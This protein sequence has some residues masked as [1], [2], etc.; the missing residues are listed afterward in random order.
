MKPFPSLSPVPPL[1]RPPAQPNPSHFR[2]I[3][4]IFRAFALLLFI[5]PAAYAS[6]FRGA[7]LTW[8]R[9]PAPANTIELTVTETWRIGATDTLNYSW[10]DGSPNFNTSG[11]TVIALD[12]A[13]SVIRKVFTH[14]YA[15]SGPYTISGTSCCRIGTLANAAN[16]SMTVKSVVDLRNNNQGSPVI[17]SPVILQMV[18]GGLNTIPIGYTD[19]DEDPVTFR[20][21][22]AAESS[23]NNIPTAGGH[24]LAVS[25]AGV[26]S[27]NTS[28]TSVGQLFAAQ[29]IATD[30]HP[31]GGTSSVPFDFIIQIVDG[32]LNRPPV[33]TGSPGPFTAAIGVPFSTTITGTDPDGGTLVVT[34]QG[35]PSGATLT[36]PSGSSA[37]QP[38]G[39][40]FNWTPT[41]ADAGASVGITIVFTDPGG[42]QA[43]RSFAISVPANQPPVANAGPDVAVFDLN[44]SNQP[45][46]VTLNG[47]SS[48]DPEGVPL[49]YEWTQ[50]SGTGVTLSSPTAV[51]PTFTAP[52]LSGGPN[53]PSEVLVF[54]LTVSDGKTSR[55]DDVTITVKHLNLPPVALAAAVGWSNEGEIVTLDGSG[56]SDPNGDSLTYTWTQIT[57]PP[58]TLSS[59]STNQPK[60]TFSLQLADPH[61][62]STEEVAFNLTVSDGIATASVGPVSIVIYNLNLPPVAQAGSPQTVCESEAGVTLTGS[63]T[64]PDGDVISSY[65]WTQIAGPQVTLVNAGS[66]TCQ[67]APP[68]VSA[69]EGSVT[70]TFQLT[71]SDA[72]SPGDSTALTA[73]SSVDV[74]VKHRNMAPIADP[75]PPQ[76][77][78]EGALVTL[79]ATGS[80]DPDGSPI[81]SYAWHQHEGSTVTLSDDHVAKPTFIAPNVGPA[82]ETL[83]FELEVSDQ[84][85]GGACGQ[86]LTSEPVKVMIHVTNVN[87]IPT[88]DAGADQTEPEGTVVMLK[89]SGSDPDENPLTFT[90]I[91]LSGQAVTLDTSDPR[92]PTFT[93]PSVPCEGASVGFQL[94]TDDGFGGSATDEVIVRVTNI[95]NPPV[96]DAGSNLVVPELS[97][98]S[99]NA[100][101]S[102]DP[103]GEAMS[104][105]WLQIEGP[106]VTLADGNT[107]RPAFTAP[108]INGGGDPNATIGFIFA[109]T[110]TDTCGGEDTDW[111]E[112]TVANQPHDPVARA[113][114]SQTLCEA[115]LVILNGAGSD[116]P[117]GDALTYRWDQIAG[118]AVALNDNTS[119]TPTFTAPYVG[120]GGHTLIFELTV[121]DPFGGVN[122]DTATIA[123]VNCN[124]PPDCHDARAGIATLWPPNH[125]M[126][127][128]GIMGVADPDGNAT[129]TITS[130]TQDEPTNGLGDGDTG[131]D[132]VIQ[133]STALIRSERSGKGNGRYYHIGF[134]AA[135]PEGSCAGSVKVYVPHDRR[136]KSGIDEGPLHDSTR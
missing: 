46:T 79:D 60:S 75:G 76:T 103:D 30:N 135:D 117:D 83:E 9:M 96:A 99:L 90:W 2:G 55:S 122:T 51:M 89:G 61:C 19:V 52:L 20:M 24:T 66:A 57:G 131:P 87:Q 13:F 68:D 43:S 71:V 53:P 101:G 15:G 109:V 36:P 35:L 29:V 123:V 50:V 116:D 59:N 107:A 58:V 81:Y 7:S 47:S 126:I 45:T 102:S 21:A 67:F 124:T 31:V 91:Q 129:I 62:D 34:H 111:V 84:V 37:P 10:G 121:M 133:G 16:A 44:A 110:V 23:I 77:V 74:T 40:V 92:N 97:P 134:T 8:K 5:S 65:G 22:T 115:D 93:A 6:H 125:A 32:T 1:E 27:W 11:A 119:S 73:I 80:Y 54:R 128:I 82:G 4:W 41:L 108:V 114:G 100:S 69:A 28:G 64:D 106:A 130:V 3:A 12:P 104:Y 105:S 94:R 17:T 39:A 132:A 26:L 78:P 86:P 49:T 120:I 72:C 88:A 25:P 63:A 14:T 118:P 95:N 56:S 112:I 42:L 38:L 127:P 113:G 70:L 33:A 98:V 136:N 18:R 48:T 85:T